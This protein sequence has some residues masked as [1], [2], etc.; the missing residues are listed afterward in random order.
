MNNTLPLPIFYYVNILY[1]IR[2]ELG[3]AFIFEQFRK[4]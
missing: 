3:E 1:N 2:V 4:N